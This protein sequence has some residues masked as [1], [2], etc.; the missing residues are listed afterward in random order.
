MARHSSLEHI[1][2]GAVEICDTADVCMETVNS[3]AAEELQN[4]HL[5]G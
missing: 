1:A 5:R 4:N 2:L 3:P